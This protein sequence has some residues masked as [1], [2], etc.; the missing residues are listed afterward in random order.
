MGGRLGFTGKN[1]L[2]IGRRL[3]SGFFLGEMLT[4]V[5]LAPDDPKKHRAGC[6][7]CSKCLDQCP[8][9]AFVGPYVLDARR[10]I[11]YLTIEHKGPIPEEL[12]PLMGNKVY[13]CDVCQQASCT[14][15]PPL[16]PRACTALCGSRTP[17][18]YCSCAAFCTGAP[19]LWVT[20]SGGVLA[21]AAPL[22]CTRGGTRGCTLS[23]SDA[24]RCARGT[25]S[26]GATSLAR[27]CS[28][29]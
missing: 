14:A 26:T 13:G 16:L 4:T 12:R 2:L 24:H 7:K 11:S 6:G 18:L 28:V 3:G 15:L 23:G 9:G 1:S 20:P 21:C 22:G 29:P 10:C 27:R 5:R 8:T 19:L 25:S 17:R